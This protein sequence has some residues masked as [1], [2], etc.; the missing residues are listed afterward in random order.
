MDIRRKVADFFALENGRGDSSKLLIMGSVV[1]AALAAGL[2][3]AIAADH[4]DGHDQDCGYWKCWQEGSHWHCYWEECHN[5]D[6][7]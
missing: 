3:H 2:G 6:C 7:P 4:C 5:N 1:V